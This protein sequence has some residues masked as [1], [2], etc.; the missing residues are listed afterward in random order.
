VSL[1]RALQPLRPLFVMQDRK[2]LFVILHD[3][4]HRN[5]LTCLCIK[6]YI[7]AGLQDVVCNSLFAVHIVNTSLNLSRYN[8]TTARFHGSLLHTACAIVADDRHDGYLSV[9]RDCHAERIALDHD[10]L[11]SCQP[12][13][14]YAYQKSGY[15]FVPTFD[16]WRFTNWSPSAWLSASTE[17]DNNAAQAKMQPNLVLESRCATGHGLLLHRVYGERQRVANALVTRER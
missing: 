17:D 16:D 12:I 14:Y 10:D 1:H 5:K 9:S 3:T 8:K 15:P 11:A 6:C 4:Q 2:L 13:D 7:L